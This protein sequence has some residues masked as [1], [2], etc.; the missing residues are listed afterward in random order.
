MKPLSTLLATT[1]AAL[2]C[3]SATTSSAQNLVQNGGFESGNFAPWTV[4]DTNPLTTNIGNSATFAFEG[5][6][7][8]NLGSDTA[9]ASLFQDINTVPG[10]TYT[11][12]F[13][14]AVDRFP[15]AGPNFFE[16]SFGSTIVFSEMNL[17]PVTGGSGDPDIGRYT[18]YSYQVVAADFTTRVQFRY[19]HG[20]DFFRLDAVSV[21]PEPSA[22]SLIAV[23]ALCGLVCAYRRSRRVA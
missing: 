11:F 12:S 4:T 13:Q 14:L 17:Q 19:Q 16:A 20:D 1:V 7:Y 9:I 2:V 6:R 10:G 15:P 21:V 23:S 3:A 18:P 5:T 22:V 8:A